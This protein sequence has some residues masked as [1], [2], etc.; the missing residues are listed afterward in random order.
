MSVIWKYQISTQGCT[1]ILMPL[2]AVVLSVQFHGEAL[3]LWVML[4]PNHNAIDRHFFTVG[5]GEPFNRFL[6]PRFLA[7]V[8]HGPYVWHVFESTA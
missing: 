6:N 5:T 1:A 7:T 3:C 4:N 8:Q 2:G